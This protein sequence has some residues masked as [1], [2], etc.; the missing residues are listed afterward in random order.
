MPTTPSL[1]VVI[2]T[3]NERGNLELLLPAIQ[4]VF[5]D[6][7]I[8][9]QIVIADDNSRDGTQELLRAYAKEHPNV[10]LHFRTGAPSLARSWYEGF[11]LADKEVIVCIDAD[12]CHDPRYFPTMLAKLME[13]YDLVIGS[14][15]SA[16]SWKLM[17]EKSFIAA[18]L[19]AVSQYMTRAI[20][21]FP[22]RDISHS[23]RMFKREVF[24]A[25][26]DRLDQEGNVFLVAF[27]FHAKKKGFRVSEVPIVYGK[28]LYGE[29]KLSVMKEGLRYLGFLGKLWNLRR[30]K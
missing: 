19:S 16:G 23:F 8:D 10:K 9:G 3:F 2:P 6:N 1:S 29:T 30:E 12:L 4:Q 7:G 20:T 28:R 13:G 15:Y 21:G 17:K 11:E 22:E 24:H 5:Q 18:A 26:K 25:V 27:L 14:R